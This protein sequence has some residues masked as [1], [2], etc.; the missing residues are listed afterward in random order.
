MT[1]QPPFQG[2]QATRPYHKQG[3]YR[4]LYRQGRHTEGGTRRAATMACVMHQ[5]QAA[6]QPV[7]SHAR[8]PHKGQEHTMGRRTETQSQPPSF[9]ILWKGP[10]VE[11]ENVP[12]GG[13]LSR[14]N[15][16]ATRYCSS[17]I[18]DSTPRSTRPPRT[19]SCLQHARAPCCLQNFLI[20]SSCK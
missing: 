9:I 14:G 3:Q 20:S 13:S 10:L 15:S 7:N 4:R 8:T 19:L 1:E 5:D 12:P 17:W 2:W 11:S 18:S 16:R 6:L